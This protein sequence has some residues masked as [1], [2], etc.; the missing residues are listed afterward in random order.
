M[1][2]AIPFHFIHFFFLK[3]YLSLNTFIWET[4]EY[5]SFV[6]RLKCNLFFIFIL[7]LLQNTKLLVLIDKLYYIY[8]SVI[9]KAIILYVKH[10]QVFLNP[11]GKWGET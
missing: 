7:F 6:C 10:F 3:K 11:S 1:Q 5:N 9:I 2:F 4:K 8:K